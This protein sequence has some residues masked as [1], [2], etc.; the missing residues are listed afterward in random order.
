M[1]YVIWVYTGKEEKTKS[2]IERFVDPDLYSRCSIPYMTKLERKAGITQKVQKLMIPS[3][4]FVETDRIDDFADALNRVPGFTVVLHIGDYYQPLDKHD[5]SILRAL[6]ADSDVVDISTA[7]ISGDR[8]SVVYG[9]LKGLEGQI[10]HID[11]H[12]RTATLEMNMF[13]RT[14]LVKVGL[15][16]VEKTKTNEPAQS[17]APGGSKQQ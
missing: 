7:Y 16:V 11:R 14:T 17:S 15:E 4:V 3:Y 12:H 6:I 10:K 2:F 9:P 8:V 5:E 1:W 13:D